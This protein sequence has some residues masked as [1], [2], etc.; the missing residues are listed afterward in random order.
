MCIRHRISLPKLPKGKDLW[1]V[2]F[3]LLMTLFLPLLSSGR[4]SL[5]SQNASSFATMGIDVDFKRPLNP[6]IFFVVLLLLFAFAF[7]LIRDRLSLVSKRKV[8][9]CLLVFCFFFLVRFLS[10]FSF[11]Y[12]AVSFLFSFEGKEVPVLYS[13]FAI[14][15]RFNTLLSDIFLLSYFLIAI[16]VVPTFKKEIMTLFRFLLVGYLLFLYVAIF[17]SLVTEG[18]AIVHSLR[19]FMGLE[20]ERGLDVLSFTT[21]RNVLGFLLFLGFAS[22]VILFVW[23]KRLFALVSLV[24]LFLFSIPV[25]SRTVLYLLLIGIVL[26]LLVEPFFLLRKQRRWAIAL[27]SL[28][29]VGILAFLLAIGIL[30]NGDFPA[31]FSSLLKKLSDGRTL[32][33]RQDIL[34]R[35]LSMLSYPYYL[36]FGYDRIPF[37]N[38]F[39]LYRNDPS[40]SILNS[41]NGL[42]ETLFH[43][44]ILGCL[45]VLLGIV[46]VFFLCRKIFL[47]KKDTGLVFLL[48]ALMQ[49]IYA[50]SEPRFLFLDDVSSILF[51]IVYFLPL[52]LTAGNPSERETLWN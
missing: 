15:E 12:G 43:F 46:Y 29:V 49:G 25:Y 14:Y 23:E 16:L 26:F 35:A 38:I 44:G 8:S 40:L 6:E 10:V 27:W 18:D 33:S 19:F 48:L 45:V 3:L 21:N 13:G 5:L 37:T 1:D 34:L 50:M 30:W 28:L 51:I 22:C 20:E 42:M 41:H 32:S 2:L 52:L 17:Y 31:F 7:F 24:I 11:P 39:S 47:R 36:V 4:I 9:L